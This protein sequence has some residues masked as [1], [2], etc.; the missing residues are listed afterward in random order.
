M[1]KSIYKGM[2][3]KVATTLDRDVLGSLDGR[4]KELG[5]TK[6]ATYIRDLIISDVDQSD[7]N[8]SDLDYAA[9]E[10]RIEE[11]CGEINEKD[12][13]IKSAAKL[14]SVVE[15]LNEAID[16]K[17]QEV[18][19]VFSRFESAQANAE[20]RGA[21]C[22]GLKSENK[23]L[24]AELQDVHQE[25]I[26]LDSRV[27]KLID[28][29]LEIIEENKE[30]ESRLELINRERLTLKEDVSKLD[31]ER[32]DINANV[33]SLT[34]DLE[35]ANKRLD[36]VTEEYEKTV[37]VLRYDLNKVRKQKDSVLRDSERYS[38]NAAKYAISI[39][40]MDTNLL[41]GVIDDYEKIQ[42]VSESIIAAK[43]NRSSYEQYFEY[44]QTEY[45]LST[46]L[47]G[48]LIHTTIGDLSKIFWGWLCNLIPGLKAK[49]WVDREAM[50]KKIKKES[51]S[52]SQE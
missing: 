30:I 7:P 33:S 4:L 8:F 12:K 37:G 20:E 35:H 18:K 14:K 49:D 41:D 38:L 16:S 47:Y 48:L 15:T 50:R 24:I 19:H 52:Q 17:D 21:E 13:E 27:T 42:M 6:R 23:G 1:S 26:N 28:E 45:D 44:Y 40:D 34:E 43:A 5:Y 3:T 25:R 2:V 11:L 31:Y 36:I 29:R 51:S 46:M 39:I 32:V 22:A 9:L 10:K